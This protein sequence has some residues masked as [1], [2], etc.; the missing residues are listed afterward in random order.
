[1]II[2]DTAIIRGRADR[3][4]EIHPEDYTVQL[5]LD[6]TNIGVGMSGGM[7]SSLLLWLLAH[8]IN[9][10][11]LDT[12]IHQWTCVHEEKPSQHIHSKKAIEFVKQ[13]FPNVKFGEHMIKMTDAKDYID[14]GSKLAWELIK[15]H[16]I[17]ALFNGVTIN[18]DEEI[19]KAV[20]KN[21]WKDRAPKRDWIHREEWLKKQEE[22][23]KLRQD[24][25]TYHEYRPFIHYDKRIVLAFYKKY[26]LLPSL[27]ALTRS[28]EGWIEDTEKFTI[29]CKGCWW[30]VE[31][32]WATAEIFNY[33]AI[34]ALSE[35]PKIDKD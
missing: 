1:M 24:N 31:K 30:C 29:E 34:D 8:H 3:V 19:G 20:W 7:D 26:G 23:L 28:C 22:E 25:S 10:N 6:H 21:I 17:T 33:D 35:W 4:D 27:G 9:E 14:N 16:N 2:T 32:E 18:P 15:K 11:N 13:S 5:N 12:T